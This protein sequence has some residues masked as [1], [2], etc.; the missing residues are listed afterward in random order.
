MEWSLYRELA[1]NTRNPDM[2]NVQ[3]IGYGLHKLSGEIGEYFFE[4]LSTKD[5]EELGDI[6]WYVALLDCEL[7]NFFGIRGYDDCYIGIE[8]KLEEVR[9]Y[10][11]SDDISCYLSRLHEM[12]GKYLHHD[13]NAEWLLENGFHR[14]LLNLFHGMCSFGDKP[15]KKVWQQNV[16]KLNDRHPEG[17]D[18]DY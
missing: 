8:H 12:W 2:N 17:F 15:V 1:M 16:K 5:D 10:I 13:K 14:N 9:E 18:S 3:A 4:P 11:F 6:F 7:E